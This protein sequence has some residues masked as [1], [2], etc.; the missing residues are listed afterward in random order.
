MALKG[1]YQKALDESLVSI[2]IGKLMLQAHRLTMIDY[3]VALSLQNNGLKTIKF[4]ISEYDIPLE[5]RLETLG[6][7]EEY[8]QNNEGLKTAL[9]G[10]Y[11]F[12]EKALD[13]RFLFYG[14]EDSNYIFHPNRLKSDYADFIRFQLGLADEKC[15]DIDEKVKEYHEGLDLWSPE[16]ELIKSLKPNAIGEIFKSTQIESELNTI[17]RRCELE[18]T[19]NEV[20]DLLVESESVT[21]EEE[22]L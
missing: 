9:L 19:F 11:E 14:L 17:D 15:E 2:Q 18:E 8:L 20:R 22:T 6:V 5:M 1:E 10:G 3:L 4:I 21:V 7:L 12:F 13:T 16:N